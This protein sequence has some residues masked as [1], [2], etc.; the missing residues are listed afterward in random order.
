[1]AS[2]IDWLSDKTAN[3]MHRRGL[4]CVFLHMEVMLIVLEKRRSPAGCE[5]RV[6]VEHHHIV[7]T[8]GG[9]AVDKTAPQPKTGAVRAQLCTAILVH[10]RG[11]V[12]CGGAVHSSQLVQCVLGAT[13]VV[14][15][16]RSHPRMSA[17]SPLT[18]L[19]TTHIVTQRSEAGIHKLRSMNIDMELRRSF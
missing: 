7:S 11:D 4:S 18:V 14:H 6:T 12:A 10:R 16:V 3:E 2:Q 15:L 19:H 13:V 5:Q 17:C 1:M 9:R 8:Y